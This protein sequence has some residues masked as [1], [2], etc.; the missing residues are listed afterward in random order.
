MEKTIIEYD[1]KEYEVKEPTILL[2]NKLS[3]LKD[4]QNDE[5][6]AITLISLSTGLSHE[7]I[8][9]ADWYSIIETS[10][11]LSEFLLNQSHDFHNEFEFE[12]EK[13]RFID[14][15]NMTFGE[16]I[17][18]DE[19]LRQPAAK[20]QSELHYFMA[21]LYREVDEN[22]KLT[23]YDIGKVKERSEK[24]K[25]LS[26]K[27]LNGAMRFFLTLRNILDENTPSSLESNWKEKL[28]KWML[29]NQRT[30][31]V[32]GGGIQQFIL[33]LKRTYLRWVKWLKSL[34]LS[35]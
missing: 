21:L 28:Q 12:G 9:D 6:F 22:G 26:I 23:P 15:Q 5:D 32:F 24:F 34:S 18:I 1:G 8:R 20:K 16:F 27:Y 11:A 10:E 29:K 35:H 4:L 31:L 25:Y 3:M 30:L 13:Y 33:W 17:D 2:W 7:E 14:L 19:Y